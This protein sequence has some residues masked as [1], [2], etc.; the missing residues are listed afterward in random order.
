MSTSSNFSAVMDRSVRS[1]SRRCSLYPCYQPGRKLACCRQPRT[2][3]PTHAFTLIELLVVISIIAL[4]ISIL[5]PAMSRAREVSRQAVC[6]TNL[7]QF[8]T[9]FINY[10][11]DY[12]SWFPAK[13]S[14]TN[15]NA[16]VTE[17]ATVQQLASP[18]WGPNFAGMIRDVVERK[19]SRD[20]GAY[21]IYLPAPKVMLCPSDRGNNKPGEDA[22][23][24]GDLWP[25]EE[26]DDFR[27]LPRTLPEQNNLRKSHISYFYVALFRTDDNGDFMMMADQSNRNDT[28]VGSLTGLTGEDNHGTRGMNFLFIDSHVEWGKPRSG[29]YQDMQEFATRYWARVFLRKPRWSGEGNGLNRSSEVQTVE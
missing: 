15:A 2:H 4:L 9:A 24:N 27:K 25:T 13:P 29:S 19:Y 22:L 1:Q 28:A 23:S 5:L 16:E 8:G 10:S 26:I 17:L 7:R 12:N 3:R 11:E 18:N 20:D 6:G 14:P 21:P